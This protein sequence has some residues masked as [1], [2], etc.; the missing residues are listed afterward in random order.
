MEGRQHALEN[1]LD[2]A[3]SCCDRCIGRATVNP[4][5]HGIGLDAVFGTKLCTWW[6][7]LV[8]MLGESAVGVASTFTT[9]KAVSFHRF[10][11]A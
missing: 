8:H 7:Q 9:V 6:H 3:P 1:F 2:A 11:L 5:G 10:F 4:F